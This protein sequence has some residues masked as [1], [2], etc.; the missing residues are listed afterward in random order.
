MSTKI[1]TVRNAV[2]DRMSVDYHPESETHIIYNL[3]LGPEVK[4]YAN[5]PDAAF[6]GFCSRL[7]TILSE[8]D[9]RT[10][11]RWC[12]EFVTDANANSLKASCSGQIGMTSS[13]GL[14]DLL[15]ISAEHLCISR[16]NL[17]QK[18]CEI[19]IDKLMAEMS[20]SP[21]VEISK[22][23]E[24]ISSKDL[25]NKS[26]VE[27]GLR[28]PNI[29]HAKILVLSNDLDVKPA[30]LCRY[31]ILKEM[32]KEYSEMVTDEEIRTPST[33]LFFQIDDRDSNP[34]ELMGE[35][36]SNYSPDALTETEFRAP[37][38]LKTNHY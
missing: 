20:E 2:L 29:L 31:L 18:I 25:T 15:K 33:E 12:S 24:D 23:I 10:L 13:E 38:K 36:V 1:E 16:N 22:T 34:L 35:L 14:R 30:L 9:E 17:V 19:G 28:I 3:R 4:S 27:W 32:L 11:S 37:D 8:A 7:D 5:W 21:T 6:N 26:K